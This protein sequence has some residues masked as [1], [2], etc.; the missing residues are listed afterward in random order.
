VKKVRAYTARELREL[1][2]A[3]GLFKLYDPAKAP[4]R[5]PVDASLPAIRAWQVRTAAALAEMVGFRDLPRAPLT[6]RLLS[7]VDKGDYIREKVLLR[8]WAHSVMPV[9]VLIPK[10]APRPVPTVLA[11]HGHCPGVREI[12][13][14]RPDG[15][16][17]DTP[18]GYQK[19]FAVALCRRGL[20]V[21][22]PEIA[23]FGERRSDYSY[24]DTALGQQAPKNCDHISALAAHLGGSTMGLRVHDARRLVDY[25]QTRPEL[26]SAR[27]GAM[28]ISG[29]GMQTFYSTAL[30]RRIRACVVSGYYCALRQS[31]LNMHHCPC[32][33]VPGLGRFGEIYDLVGLIAPRPMLAEAGDRDGIFPLAGVRKAMARGRKVYAHFGAADLLQ[34]DYFQGDHQISGRKAYD[35]LYEHLTR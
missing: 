6:A 7:R 16:E 4:Y 21:A 18:E 12:V 19:D 3:H 26:D 30:D 2:P 17:R 28:G 27:L 25:L 11:F 8:T 13:G 22:A 35:F 10:S 29:G 14:I 15:S 32:N 33:F 9:Y 20:A 5:F 34:V 31:I 23:C 1:Q 24:L